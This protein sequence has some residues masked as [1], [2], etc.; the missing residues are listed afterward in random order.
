MTAYKQLSNA[1]KLM[2]NISNPPK[3]SSG[4]GVYGIVGYAE[5]GPPVEMMQRKKIF[6]DSLKKKNKKLRNKR[7]LKVFP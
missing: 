6:L 2:L 3:I 5:F 1:T 4:N 7:S